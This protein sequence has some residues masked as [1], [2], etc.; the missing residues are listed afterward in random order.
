MDRAG[1]KDPQD[2]TFAREDP[3]TGTVVE[4]AGPNG[5]NVHYDAPHTSRGPAHDKPHVGWSTGGKR[6][7]PGY[8]HG[9]FSYDGPQHP[10]RPG[11][12]SDDSGTLS[13][14]NDAPEESRW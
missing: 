6:G 13:P 3:V 10:S 7:K 2:V 9:N 8:E 5:R 11:R 4:F 1:L 14:E 12:A